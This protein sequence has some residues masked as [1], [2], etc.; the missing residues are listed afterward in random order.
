MSERCTGKASGT[1]RVEPRSD[2]LVRCGASPYDDD[3]GYQAAARRPTALGHFCSFCAPALPFRKGCPDEAMSLFF[4][5]LLLAQGQAPAPEDP[6]AFFRFMG[7]LLII[8]VLFWFMLIRPQKRKEH[9]LREMVH[10]LKENDRVVTIGGVYGV[11]TNVQR[12]AERVT[13]RVDES[14][15]TKLKVNMSAIARVM[16]G[17]EQEGGTS[18]NKS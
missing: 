14:T 11:V 2:A 4:P 15:G 1:P 9:E 18:G 13:I 8:M 3:H 17:D 10:N 7:P 12:D 5:S 16:T 6:F